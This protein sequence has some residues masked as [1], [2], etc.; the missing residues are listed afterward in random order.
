MELRVGEGGQG[1]GRIG[2]RWRKATIACL[3]QAKTY[4]SPSLFPAEAL[5]A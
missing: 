1:E 4:F 2:E 3:T 5:V